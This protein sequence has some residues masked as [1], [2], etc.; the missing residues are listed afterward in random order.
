MRQRDDL[1]FA[2]DVQR[3][4]EKLEGWKV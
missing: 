3:A 2:E 4:V 1:M